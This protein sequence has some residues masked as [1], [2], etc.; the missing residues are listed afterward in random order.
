METFRSVGEFES[1]E[2]VLL[3]W[4]LAPFATRKLSLDS[5]SIQV[6]QALVGEV[7]III[8]CYD[9]QV[10]R[11][12]KQALT[13]HNIDVAVIRVCSVSLRYFLSTRF[14]CRSHGGELWRTKKGGFSL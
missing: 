9:E 10:K 4:P 11:R 6:V 2:S 12:A 14:W 1:Q 5:C 7:E 3:I 8:C 13:Q